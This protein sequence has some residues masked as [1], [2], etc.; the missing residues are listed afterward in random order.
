MREARQQEKKAALQRFEEEKRKR[1]ENAKREAGEYDW[2][3]DAYV[4]DT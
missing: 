2:D 3:S 4:D 1:R